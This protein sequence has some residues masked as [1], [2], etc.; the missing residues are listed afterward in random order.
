ME[1][2]VYNQKAEAVG[3]IKLPENV[4]GLKWNADLVHQVVTGLASNERAGTAHARGRGDV[5]GGGKKPWKQKG[6]GRARHGSTRSPIWKGGGVTHGPIKDKVYTKKINKKM[7]AKA[8]F[9]VL[10]DKVKNGEVLFIDQLTLNEFKTKTANEIVKKFAK[11][12]GFEKLTNSKKRACLAF[13]TR[14][15]TVFRSFKNIPS[16]YLEDVKNLNPLE[17]M[18][19]KYLILV[20]PEKCMKFFEMK[21]AK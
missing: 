2:T 12:K 8:L 18:R 1:T 19:Y 16:V 3:K 9:T 4:F 15:D 17:V 5:S 7:K 11:I 20:E 6:T 14:A 13:C 21:L 10:S